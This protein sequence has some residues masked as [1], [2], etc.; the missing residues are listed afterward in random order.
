MAAASFIAVTQL[1]TRP[2]L[3]LL[4]HVAIGLFALSLPIF[5]VVVVTWKREDTLT[6]VQESRLE[7]AMGAATIAFFFG[8]IVLFS[9]FN[10]IYGVVLFLSSIVAAWLVNAFNEADTKTATPNASPAP[11]GTDSPSAR[12]ARP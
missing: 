5:V 7:N 3:N 8:V 2:D 12:N 11:D 9:S 4:H 1:T 10:P 6:K